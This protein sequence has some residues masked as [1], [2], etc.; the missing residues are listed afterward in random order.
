MFVLGEAPSRQSYLS[1]LGERERER[2][3]QK[4]DRAICVRIVV[5]WKE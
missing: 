5:R 3:R 2:E 1:S 4:G